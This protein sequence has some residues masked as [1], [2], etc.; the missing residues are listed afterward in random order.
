MP[1]TRADQTHDEGPHAEP[2]ET[3]QDDRPDSLLGIC[4]ITGDALAANRSTKFLPVSV[5]LGFFIG[6]IG[7]AFGR[8]RAAGEN[9]AVVFIN[10]EAYSIAF[11][12]CYFWI[13]STVMLA[14][15]IGAS[16][17]ED[18]LPRILHRFLGDVKRRAKSDKCEEDVFKM[19]RSFTNVSSANKIGREKRRTAGGVYSWQPRDRL[20]VGRQVKESVSAGPLQTLDINV[21]ASTPRSLIARISAGCLRWLLRVNARSPLLS[22]LNVVSGTIAGLLICARVPPQGWDCRSCG[23]SSMCITWLVSAL[24]DLPISIARSSTLIRLHIAKDFVFTA[25]TFGFVIITQIGLCT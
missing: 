9:S 16:Q 1:L 5:A 15:I 25:F 24:L 12:A 4:L 20:K 21:Y 3:I 8:T 11:T 17:T 7:I 22:I 13:I 10:I 14:A 19:L 6:S 18:S 2:L 23:I